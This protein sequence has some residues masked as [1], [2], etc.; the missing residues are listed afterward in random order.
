MGGAVSLWGTTTVI[1]DSTF[2][3]NSTASHAEKG[4]S[5]GGALY[6]RS[7]VWG[8]AENLSASIKNS[9]FD[10]NSVKGTSAQGGAL[11]AKS[12]YDSEKDKHYIL[13]LDLDNV[14]F[15]NNTSDS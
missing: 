15:K 1:E 4:S 7:G 9:T 12:D 13:N 2:T 8:G 14:T 5:L 10:G 6:L 11:Y 3:N